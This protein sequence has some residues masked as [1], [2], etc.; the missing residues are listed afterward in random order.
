LEMD[1][2]A[3]LSYQ[4][5]TNEEEEEGSFRKVRSWS[6]LV[7][8]TGRKRPKVR[9]PG[10]RR[11]LRRRSRFLSRVK[12]SMR[13]ALKRLKNGQSHMNDLFGGNFMLMHVNPT[14]FKCGDHR[15]YMG[16]HGFSSKYPLEKIA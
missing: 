13:K 5:L 10:L 8:L 4:R 6:K 7:K 9:I 16:H 12:V 1:L 2:M 11:F 15:P 3:K 14:G